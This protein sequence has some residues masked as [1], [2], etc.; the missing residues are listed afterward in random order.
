MQRTYRFCVIFLLFAVASKAQNPCDIVASVDK[1]CV[2][3]PVQYEFNT[4][5]SSQEVSYLWH[6][7]DGDSSV[8]S[9]PLHVFTS[10]GSYV[11]DVTV[12]FKN[13]TKCTVSL[14]KAIVVY[15]NPLADFIVNNNQA[16]LLCARGNSICFADKSS[17]GAERRPLWA[18][19]WNFGDGQSSTK[20]NPCYAYSDSGYYQVTLQVTDSNGCTNTIQKIISVRYTT[21]IGLSLTPKFS[22]DLAFDCVKDVEVATF[23]D[24]TDT[25]GQYITKFI[26]KFGDG[27]E[28]SCDLR[29]PGCLAQWTNFQHT[30]SIAGNYYPSLYI[31]NKYGCSGF[32]SIRTPII[33]QPYKLIPTL[34]PNF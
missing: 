30:Y 28:D 8:Q 15:H 22:V 34:F 23:K 31:E 19:Q 1:G 4:T 21:D 33:V 12:T 20:Q 26:W 10:A 24:S 32:D 13:G 29:N 18:W 9:N 25:A 14:P 2:P 7:G 3:L 27:T 6:F 16:I 17:T 5:N 11:T